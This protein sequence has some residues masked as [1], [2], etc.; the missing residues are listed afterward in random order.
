[1]KFAERPF[2]VRGRVYTDLV[3][4]IKRIRD[5]IED[6]K[7]LGE[8][9]DC[10]KEVTVEDNYDP[11]TR[12]DVG[13]YLALKKDTI[14]AI[15]KI[16]NYPMHSDAGSPYVYLMWHNYHH[17]YHRHWYLDIFG[18]WLCQNRLNEIIA[19]NE[20]YDSCPCPMEWVETCKDLTNILK[21][22]SMNY[23]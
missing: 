23:K 9:S 7:I 21:K 19:G 20:K 13:V 8:E 14:R 6:I 2:S 5:A 3:Y 17:D 15:N 10:I 1:M 4:T 16:F 18:N 12:S 11:A 22:Y